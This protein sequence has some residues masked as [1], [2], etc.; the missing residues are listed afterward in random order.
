MMD[1]HIKLVGILNIVYRSLTLLGALFLFALAICF[2]HLIWFISQF[3]HHGEIQE[4]PPI[5]FTLVPIIL[6]CIGII[7]TVV[8]IIGI[9][10][11]SGVLKKKEWARITLLV[12]SFFTLL[13][14]PLG[15]ALGIYSI[16]T[17]LND[18]VI[19]QFN[20]KKK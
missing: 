12:V 13:R 11:A 5:V 7:A 16:W 3:D 8:S 4:I 19:K 6:V 1:K 17:L 2:R 20:S 14:F 9:I 18:D 10:A 15:T